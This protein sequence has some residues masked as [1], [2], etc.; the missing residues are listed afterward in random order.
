M[1]RLVVIAIIALIAVGVVLLISKIF[2]WEN[3]VTDE[4]AERRFKQ[5]LEELEK[6]KKEGKKL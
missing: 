1:I 2:E 3:K 6:S 4:E 5:S